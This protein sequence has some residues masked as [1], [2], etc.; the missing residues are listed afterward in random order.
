MSTSFSANW[1]P[2]AVTRLHNCVQCT[3]LMLIMFSFGC[4]TL[5][6]SMCTVITLALHSQ[7]A[8]GITPTPHKVQ[9]GLIPGHEGESCFS[10]TQD[11]TQ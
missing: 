3:N 8:L 2:P 4:A 10:H 5:C 11:M 1:E 7:R 9:E 6:A